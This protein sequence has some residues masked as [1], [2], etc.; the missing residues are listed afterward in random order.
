VEL[1]KQRIRTSRSSLWRFLDRHGVMLKKACKPRN[2]S[3][4]M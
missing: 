1:R 3:K 2:G 4:P